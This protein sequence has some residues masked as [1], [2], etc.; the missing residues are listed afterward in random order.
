MEGQI[1]FAILLLVVFV[2]WQFVKPGKSMFDK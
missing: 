1:I 2:L